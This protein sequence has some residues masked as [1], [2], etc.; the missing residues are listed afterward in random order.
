MSAQMIDTET[1]E[2]IATAPTGAE[3]VPVDNIAALESLD[4]AGREVAVGQMLDQA[5]AW[6]AHVRA[7]QDV[8]ARDIADFR[9]FIATAA[10]AAR[11]V[12][13]SKEC[14]LDAEEIVRRSER[15]LGLAIRKGQDAGEIARH[16][17]HDLHVVEILPVNAVAGVNSASS[18]TPLYAM[19]D[20]VTDEQFDTAL[21]E[22]KSEGNLSRANVVRKVKGETAKPK[23]ERH[24]LLRKTRH[25]DPTR[26]ARETVYALEGLATGV[27][28]IADLMDQIDREEAAAQEWAASLSDSLRALNRFSKQIKETTHVQ[29]E[30]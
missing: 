5:R 9:N 4:A 10:E 20:G 17:S 18:V 8:H 16:G 28:L 11:R 26:V 22:A 1:G 14:Q 2:I 29:S 7:A 27:G 19:A 23:S 25:I 6:L 24:E 21:A 13:V 12:K 3:L 15:E 30:A